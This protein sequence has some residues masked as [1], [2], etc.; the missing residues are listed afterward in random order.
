M[1]TRKHLAGL[2]GAALVSAVAVQPAA[3]DTFRFALGFPSGAP[4]EAAK[5][6]AE[7]VQEYTDKKHRV[8]I[9]ELSLLNHS[10]M[11]EGIG[12]GLADIGY[13]LTAYS[14]SDY[15][16][17]NMAA[18]LSMVTA[19]DDK[20]AGQEGYAYSGA[21]LEYIMLNCDEC[22]DEFSKNNQVYTSVVST[23]AYVMFCNDPIDTVAAVEG[24]RLRTSG[25]PWARWARSFN[26]QPVSLPVGEVYEALSQG[27]V[28][29][30]FLSP[31]EL[32]NFN[33]I[34]VVKNITTDV[35]G[36][37]YAAGGS[38]TLNKS[39]WDAFSTE[40]KA[41]FL[42]AGSVMA[43]QI[44]YLYQQ[45]ATE[46]M[47]KAEARGLNIIQAQPDLLA[48]SQ[49]FIKKDLEY[50]PQFYADEY[51]LDAENLKGKAEVMLGLI[52]KWQGLIA[53]ANIQSAD[54]LRDLYWEQVYSK[55][56][57]AKYSPKK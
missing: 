56:D 30:A 12:K 34:E 51:K 1:S 42:K 2:I 35:P 36:G 9:F 53:N 48:K 24:K 41:A 54:D 7:A 46:D 43:A 47:K 21:M 29:C 14:P 44:T 25:A 50:V 31:T 37:L 18:D 55:I 6:Y 16:F 20:I 39:K 8:R 52:E 28:D 5:K 22:Q 40:E 15:P 33:L 19:L 11:S 10:E 27:V 57:P 38:S 26:A 3:A 45:Q 4:I 23:P 13:L 49:E 17:S 32:T